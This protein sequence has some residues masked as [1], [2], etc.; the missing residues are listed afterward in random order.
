MKVEVEEDGGRDGETPSRAKE[1]TKI[2]TRM[3]QN[4]L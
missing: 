4:I 3:G 1:E 2:R